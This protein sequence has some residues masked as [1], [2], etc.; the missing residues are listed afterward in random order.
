MSGGAKLAV[1]VAEVTP[2][3][4]LITRFGFVARDGGDLPAFSGGAH[5]VVE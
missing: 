5:V 1:R 3:N 2:V 4:D